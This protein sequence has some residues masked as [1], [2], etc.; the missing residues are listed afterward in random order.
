MLAMRQF[1]GNIIRDRVHK[2]C[3]WTLGVFILIA[4]WV[5]QSKLSFECN[6]KAFV[7]AAALAVIAAVRLGFLRDLKKGFD[8]QLR[9]AK[10]I[11]QA[12]HMFDPSFYDSQEQIYPQEWQRSGTENGREFVGHS[13]M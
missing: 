8:G 9:A 6:E 13:P 1:P 2:T 3:T 7:C 10:N 4:G 11:E 5:V 12:L